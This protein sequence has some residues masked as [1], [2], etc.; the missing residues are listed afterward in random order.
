MMTSLIIVLVAF[1]SMEG[2]SYAA[3]RWLMHGPGMGWHASHHG[4]A[5]EGWERNDRF[6]L[7]FSVIGFAA[8]A[9]GTMGPAI[10]WLVPVGIGMV[11]YGAAYLFVHEVYIHERLP[12]RVPPI[13]ALEHLR[14]AHRLH[15]LF[16]G[17]PYGMLLPIVPRS[18]RE[19]AEA[20]VSTRS[21]RPRL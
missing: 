16:G 5:G 18:V 11:L 9:L 15:H 17:E 20:R 19:R 12:F 13:A 2:V 14:E 3:H 8:F 4:P 6:P 1:L 10:G 21:I 7:C